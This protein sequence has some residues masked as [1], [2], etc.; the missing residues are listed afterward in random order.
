MLELVQSKVSTVVQRR[1]EADLGVDFPSGG[2]M[3]PMPGLVVQPVHGFLIMAAARGA[4]ARGL[5]AILEMWGLMQPLV[6]NSTFHS[7]TDPVQPLTTLDFL[8][9]AMC[10]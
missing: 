7:P 6:A 5:P 2:L 9:I 4:A 10:C 3:Q 1:S 8:P